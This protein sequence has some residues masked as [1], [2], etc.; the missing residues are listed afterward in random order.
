MGRGAF[1]GLRVQPGQ[2]LAPGAGL[3]AQ[4]RLVVRRQSQV[5]ASER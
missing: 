5:R 3:G 1:S 4:G 2:P